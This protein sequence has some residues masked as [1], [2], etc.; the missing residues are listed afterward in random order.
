MS[1]KLPSVE[2]SFVGA[3]TLACWLK[4]HNYFC[5]PAHPS[6]VSEGKI[7]PSFR[8]AVVKYKE[9][10]IRRYFVDY[11][12]EISISFKDAAADCY[13]IIIPKSFNTCHRRFATCKE[14]CHILT[15]D[16]DNNL[17]MECNPVMDLNRA[18]E[19]VRF[20]Q[21]ASTLL[22]N[23][24]LFTDNPLTSEG[25]CFLLTL[26]ILIPIKDRPAIV[27]WHEGRVPHYNIAYHLKIP[28]KLVDFFIES[29]YDHAWRRAGGPQIISGGYPTSR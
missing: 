13:D 6:N 14:L 20:V 15:D 21:K 12:N 5:D 19:T 23:N 2:R 9:K 17:V 11:L 7:W 16:V 4:K 25:F 1:Q 18:L 3:I 26:E 22:A 10:E 8:D 28:E 29:R 27:Y 24:P